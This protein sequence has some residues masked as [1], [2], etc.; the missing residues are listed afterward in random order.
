MKILNWIKKNKALLLILLIGALLRFFRLDFQSVWLD[1]LHTLNEANPNLSLSESYKLLL[2]AEPHPP[3]YFILV[4]YILM[5]FGYTPFVLRF[6]S[7]FVGVLGIAAI[8]YLGEELIDKRAG[9]IAAVLLAINPFHLTHSQDGRM[10]ALLLLTTTISFIYL[11]KFLKKP[12][13]KSAIIYGI[14]STLM[15]YCHFFALF[16]LFSQYLILLYFLI[17]PDVIKRIIFFKYCLIAGLLTLVLYLP[18]YQLFIKTSEIKSFWIQ[19]PEKDVFTQIFKDFFGQSEMVLFLIVPVIIMFFVKLFSQKETDSF[20]IKPEKNNLIFG[21]FILFV[22]IITTLILPLIRTYL[23]LPMIVNRYFINI[24]PAVLLLIA[25]G[26]YFIK[27]RTV[28]HTFLALIV[29]FS[30]TDIF[31]VK[32][33]YSSYHNAQF[34]EA[35]AF[36]TANHVE[37]EMIY[38]SLSW[39]FSYFFNKEKNMKTVD[40][41]LDALVSEMNQ[42]PSK[43]KSFWYL[44]AQNHPLTA[45]DASKEY[46][47]NNFDVY[48]KVELFDAWAVHYTTK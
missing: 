19:M 31:V 44:D 18:T 14:F 36:V 9:L 47:R 24:L 37:G 1:E 4:H 43:K 29:V 22:W 27:N 28:Q 48:D 34:R 38:T 42:D 26:I 20:S 16:A 33:Y 7:A 15:I 21:Y 23:T 25:I 3:L 41:T 11:I 46:L 40:K 13:Y 8:Y 39:H 12:S 6:F 17:F 30:L 5:I 2:T 32:K 35:A 10:Y 45:T